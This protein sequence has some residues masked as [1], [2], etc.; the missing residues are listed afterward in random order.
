MYAGN[1]AGANAP[2]AAVPG[3]ISELGA[4]AF[5]WGL[6][7][8]PPT[9]SARGVGTSLWH[10]QRCLPSGGKDSRLPLCS[11]SSVVS[12]PATP[13]QGPAQKLSVSFH[14]LHPTVVKLQGVC[15]GWHAAWSRCGLLLTLNRLAP[16]AALIIDA[17]KPALRSD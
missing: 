10:P 7:S 1:P 13:P 11:M 5:Q 15:G 16:T 2:H 17:G 8:L 14:S 6:G 9:I 12:R 3:V 4:S